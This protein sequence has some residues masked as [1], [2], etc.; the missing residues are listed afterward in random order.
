MNNYTKL[1][2]CNMVK[3]GIIEEKDFKDLL[4]KSKITT[5]CIKDFIIKSNDFSLE[6]INN[7]KII[8]FD[9]WKDV[10][11][12]Y[13]SDEIPILTNLLNSGS[14]LTRQELIVKT[15]LS[16]YKISNAIERLLGTPVDNAV[17]G[18]IEE[19]IVD[20]I[21]LGG[22]E[23]LIFINKKKFYKIVKNGRK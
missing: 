9:S 20:I 8:I 4:S 16:Q 5:K 14:V 2:L 23:K 17:T 6:D 12:T 13:S 18:L 11:S 3:D 15:K 7:F 21:P 19:G 10:D 1:K 22:N